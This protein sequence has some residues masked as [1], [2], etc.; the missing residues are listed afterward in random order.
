LK[1]VVE[2][3]RR[4]RNTM[5]F[6]LANTDDFNPAKDSIAVADM[7]EIDR[8]AIEMVRALQASVQ[9]D[10]DCYDFH[11]IV[12]S[13]QT[14]CSEDLGAFY[15]DVLKDRLYTT[16]PNSRARRSA[17]T[18]LWII[19]QTMLRLMAPI[20][21]FTTEEIWTLLAKKESGLPESIMLSDGA[22]LP[23]VPDA[24][25]LRSKWDRI[26]AVRA[27]VAKAMEAVRT[28]GGI[29]SSLQAEVA[30]TAPAED[31]AA[32]ASIGD[33]LKF[34]LISSQATV[35][36]GDTLQVKVTASPEAKCE[37]CWHQRESVG[38]DANHP[39]WC[40]R[41]V[42]NVHGTGEVRNYA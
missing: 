3:Y 37:R 35:K 42:S 8:Y 24:D 20:L 25:A 14:F 1:R 27:E 22:P 18:A 11:H 12:Q 5:R 29:G 4:I 31:A 28:E 23:V 26:R 13:L 38:Q 30:I 40:D 2:G 36:A 19:T 41:C 9:A 6:L 32:L 10:Y 17:Q 21:S 39:G 34:V 16:A 33:D 7:L 15:L